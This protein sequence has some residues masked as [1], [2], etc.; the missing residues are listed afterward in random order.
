MSD[1]SSNS[2]VALVTG[3]AQRIGR[4]TAETLHNN[5][6]RVIIHCNRSTHAASEFCSMLNAKRSGSAHWIQADLNKMDDVARLGKEAKDM[7]GKINVLVN[8]ASS[9]YPTKVNEVTEDIWNDLMASN[10]KAPFFLIQALKETLTDNSG[11]VINMVDI[12]AERPLKEYPVYCMA[13]AGLAMLTKSLSREL[14]PKIRVNGIAPGAIL[15]H[16]NELSE[17]DKDQ[18]LSEI[19]L[20]RLGTPDDIAQAILFLCTSSYITGQIL[21]VDGG[22]SVNGGSKA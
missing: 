8:N 15:W 11:V 14:A 18:V 1:H 9:F 7:F 5:G 17:S 12:H 4:R 21:A 19:A 22:R 10:L 13:K 20:N 16:E 3:A 6:Y 2:P